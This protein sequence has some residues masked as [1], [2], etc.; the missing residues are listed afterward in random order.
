MTDST[1][2][3][4]CALGPTGS[5][6]GRVQRFYPVGRHDDFN[7]PPRVEAIKLVEQLQHGPL[8]LPL[9]PRV[10]VIPRGECRN[11]YPKNWPAGSV[12]CSDARY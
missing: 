9:S 4:R 6:E 10:G 3:C 1:A 7:V 8:D 2:S 5:D 12:V 11:L